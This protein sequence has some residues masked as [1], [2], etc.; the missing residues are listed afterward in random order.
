[1][2]VSTIRSHPVLVRLIF[3]MTVYAFAISL[4]ML[5]AVFMAVAALG[6]LVSAK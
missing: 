1:M 3:L 4:P 2:A 6:V 5:L